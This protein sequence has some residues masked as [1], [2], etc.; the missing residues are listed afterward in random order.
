[1]ILVAGPYRSGTGDD[2][3]RL[4]ANVHAMNRTALALFRAGHLPVTGEALA[5]PL[6]D[7]AGSTG[8]GDPLFDEIFHPVAERLLAR[9]DAVLRIGGPSQGADRMVTRA[10]DQGKSVYTGLADVP[11][12]R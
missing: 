9:C 11:A 1:M 2:P 6:L 7:T 4:E 3:H 5:L 12:A 8:P 10:H